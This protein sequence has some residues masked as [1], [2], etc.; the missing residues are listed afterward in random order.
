LERGE[1]KES[2]VHLASSPL[3]PCST[4]DMIKM[5]GYQM[6]MMSSD[7]RISNDYDVK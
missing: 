6:I 2:F 3:D 5:E 7:G 4:F 1:K